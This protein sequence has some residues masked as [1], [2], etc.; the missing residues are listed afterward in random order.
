MNLV[1]PVALNNL[2]EM[3]EQADVAISK[4]QFYLNGFVVYF[5]GF[6]NANAVCHNSSY[7]NKYG[8]WETMGF[9]WDGDD[10]SVLNAYELVSEIR[11]VT[12]PETICHGYLDYVKDVF[13]WT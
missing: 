11:N 4:V 1:Y 3:C 7:G 9:P 6:P 5:E 10:V 12:N 13:P 2:I 8:L